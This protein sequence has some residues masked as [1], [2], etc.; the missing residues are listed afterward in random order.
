MGD[1]ERDAQVLNVVAGDGEIRGT[2][3]LPCVLI[4]DCAGASV[5]IDGLGRDQ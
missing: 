2:R 5:P 4:G 1:G 3:K